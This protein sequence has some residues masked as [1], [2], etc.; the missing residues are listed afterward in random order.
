MAEANPFLNFTDA[1]LK[2]S[3]RRAIRFTAI[4]AVAGFIVLAVTAG[5]QTGALFI[6][7]ALISMI[8]LY[9]WQQLIG[10][11]NAK[12]DNQKTP[13]ST[14]FT[15]TMFLLRMGIAVLIIYASLRCFH[16]SLYA[17]VAGL[18]LA[19]LAL[20]IEAVRLVRS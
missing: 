2:A 17:L 20:T 3:M 6:A 1:D 13:R 15:L 18:G 19:V 11:I 10:V 12:L 16:G 7:G 8:G 4:L 14:G 9:E 5:W